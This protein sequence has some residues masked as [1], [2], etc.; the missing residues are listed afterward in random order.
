MAT[1]GHFAIR[2][3]TDKIGRD[4]EIDTFESFSVHMNAGGELRVKS[5]ASVH[6]CTDAEI[7]L[8][9]RDRIVQ[10]KGCELRLLYFAP[11]ETVVAGR[12]EHICFLQQGN[13]YVV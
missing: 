12:I 1:E 3:L 7:V 11:E 4:L 5:A 10:I 8:V 6:V 9:C 13:A 2:D